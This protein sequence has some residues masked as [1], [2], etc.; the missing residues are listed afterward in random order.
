LAILNDL[1]LYTSL[2]VLSFGKMAS[3]QND[4]EILVLRR[5]MRNPWLL[6][7][8]MIGE[9]DAWPQFI[10]KAFWEPWFNDHNRMVV[11]TFAYMNGVSETFLHEV[12]TFTLKHNYTRARRTNVAY[13][14]SYFDDPLHGAERRSR[15][16]S[17]DTTMK[18]VYY[19]DGRIKPRGQ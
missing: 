8:M 5:K 11:V 14:Y 9:A 17:F 15:A 1:F 18:G 13:R 2:V 12:L 10:R 16:Y 3:V 4:A 7:Q 6:L 19:L